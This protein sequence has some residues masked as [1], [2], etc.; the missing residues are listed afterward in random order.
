MPSEASVCAQEPMPWFQHDANAASDI[1]CERLILRCGNSGY[2]AYWR[3]CEK[4]AATKGHRLPVAT[5]ED[6]LILA[7]ALGFR[8]GGSFDEMMASDECQ[9]FIE[10]LIEIGLIER[11]GEGYIQS[12]RMQKNALYFGTQK[13]NGRKGGRP[14]KKTASPGK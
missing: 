14:P 3:L 10:T 5:E 8:T 6:W 7:T 4:L 9:R 13:A 2:G 11:D 1:R 12:L